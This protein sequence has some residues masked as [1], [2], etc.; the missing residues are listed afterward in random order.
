MV[1]IPSSDTAERGV[2]DNL[3]V[4]QVLEGYIA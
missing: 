4:A 1:V 3:T 2:E